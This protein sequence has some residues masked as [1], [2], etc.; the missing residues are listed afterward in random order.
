MF[1]KGN[2]VPNQVPLSDKEKELAG[3]SRPQRNFTRELNLQH[4]L[5]FI[6]AA[7]ILFYV[8]YKSLYNYVRTNEQQVLI[9]HLMEYKD[10]YESGSIQRLNQRFRAASSQEQQTYLILITD[11]Q[12]LPRFRSDPAESAFGV[13]AFPPANGDWLV[14]TSPLFDG[15]TMHVAKSVTDSMRL[16]VQMRNTF[17]FTMIGSAILVFGGGA[18]MTHSALQPIRNM[19]KTA[20][21]IISTGNLAARVAT[22]KRR[23]ELDNLAHLFNTMLDRNQNL[24]RGMREA[25]DNVAHDLRT[26]ITRLCASLETGLQVP[27]TEVDKMREALA[28][29]MEESDRILTILK[30]LMDV[31]EAEAGMLKLHCESFDAKVLV[32]RVLDLYELVAEESCIHIVGEP[33]LSVQI[34]ADQTRLGQV[35]A[36]LV[37]NAVKYTSKGGIVTIGMEDSADSLCIFVQ[38]TGIGIPPEDQGKIW[39]RLYRCDAS[40]SKKGLGLGLCMVRAVVEAHGGKVEL[41]SQV[42]KGSRFSIRLPHGTPAEKP[43]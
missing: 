22:P 26:P 7:S 37:D 17:I 27:D 18:Y 20:Q 2:N 12:Q 4:T 9:Q 30:V 35:V 42:G 10:W 1:S 13:S 29:G 31:S 19:T 14:L 8:A 11:S 41:T 39:Q 33:L 43:L 24:I 36:N 28:D 16:L 40:R 32:T 34:Y 25:L 15:R 23:D 21:N 6:I 5:L 38:D 3:N